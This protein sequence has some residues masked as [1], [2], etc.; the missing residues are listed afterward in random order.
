VSACR[1]CPEVP[2]AGPYS[3]RN[4]GQQRTLLVDQRPARR[5]LSASITSTRAPRFSLARRKSPGPRSALGLCRNGQARASVVTN[6]TW[7]QAAG[8]PPSGSS[9]WGML[10]AANQLAVPRS[11]TGKSRGS[12]A[13]NRREKRTYRLL[14]N[15]APD[16][17]EPPAPNSPNT[18]HITHQPD[19]DHTRSSQFVRRSPSHPDSQPLRSVPNRAGGEAS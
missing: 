16:W 6:V 18:L 14:R 15:C 3:T 10:Q 17:T 5:L 4:L 7:A 13:E 12:A 1:P 9:N 2:G 11:L 8:R 19:Q